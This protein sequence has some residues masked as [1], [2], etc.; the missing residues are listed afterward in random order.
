MQLLALMEAQGISWRGTALD[1]ADAI[2]HSPEL[3]MI[4]SLFESA[5]P[6]PLSCSE[7]A[8]VSAH[9]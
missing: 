9:C 1:E 7:H 2:P 5:K 3:G 4:I 6:T 8:S